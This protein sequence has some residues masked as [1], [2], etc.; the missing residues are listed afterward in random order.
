M[1][2]GSFRGLIVEV[3]LKSAFHMLNLVNIINRYP[4]NIL[5]ARLWVLFLHHDLKEELVIIVL[6]TNE[7]NCQVLI[8]LNWI[9]I[10][11]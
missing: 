2:S 8:V 10:Q 9:H 3:K 7:T 11:P 5:I 1:I 6:V 4:E